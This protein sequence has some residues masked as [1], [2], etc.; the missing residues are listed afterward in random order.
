MSRADREAAEQ[1]RNLVGGRSLGR[2]RSG[3]SRETPRETRRD[4]EVA[5]ESRSNA[6]GENAPTPASPTATRRRGQE[7]GERTSLEDN[8]H[9]AGQQAPPETHGAWNW[10]GVD[11]ENIS[12]PAGSG[13]Q[14]G[15]GL[16]ERVQTAIANMTRGDRSVL[17]DE[18]ESGEIPII[19]DDSDVH[20]RSH[21]TTDIE[22]NAAD[23]RHAETSSFH[24]D[25]HDSPESSVGH[26]WDAG[27]DYV[28][29]IPNGP[30]RVQAPD[31]FAADDGPATRVSA[32]RVVYRNDR[33]YIPNFRCPQSGVQTTARIEG[34][35]SGRV[36]ISLT[37]FS[38]GLGRPAYTVKK[39]ELGIG[40]FDYPD[41]NMVEL[42]ALRTEYRTH[43]VPGILFVA[44][45]TILNPTED[46]L[47]STSNPQTWPITYLKLKF[48][49]NSTV[50][51]AR[52]VWISNVRP[53]S[54]A[55]DEHFARVR[56]DPPIIPHPPAERAR[57]Q[58][59]G[60][61][62]RASQSPAPQG[63]VA[64]G[65]RDR[66][67][68]Q[69]ASA[70]PPR[71]RNSR[72]AQNQTLPDQARRPSSSNATQNQREIPS[73]RGVSGQRNVPAQNESAQG[74]IASG[75]GVSGQ[76]DPPEH[77]LVK[78]N[79][80]TIRP[81]R[82]SCRKCI[83]RDPNATLRCGCRYHVRCLEF[84]S[85]R[86][87]RVAKCLVRGHTAECWPFFYF[88]YSDIYRFVMVDAAN[89][90]SNGLP[91]THGPWTDPFLAVPEDEDLSCSICAERSE[92]GNMN[93]RFV[94]T[95]CTHYFHASCLG[96]WFKHEDMYMDRLTTCPMCRQEVDKVW[97]E[98]RWWYKEEWLRP[99]NYLDQVTS[100][101]FV[102]PV[103]PE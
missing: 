84:G 73:G 7:V 74:A 8:D 37:P 14:R 65:Q 45:T 32:P 89:F 79:D 33:Y 43:G 50:W 66:S 27:D 61:R 90:L 10:T 72:R 103:M 40:R 62:W 28:T 18:Q 6:G 71:T 82:R 98:A 26:G 57:L 80:P 47:T 48:H 51:A 19:M 11:N 17:D 42:G 54:L 5:E 85:A 46:Q 88:S 99:T 60:D 30:G 3:L 95:P 101:R 38:I 24:G 78:Y 25:Y 36:I 55:I 12:A 92:I 21:T 29:R 9:S 76:Q 64:T 77:W 70:P 102:G 13:T 58:E 56:Q 1:A 81:L 63:P 23:D 86:R 96:E 20:M 35:R 22:G 41:I 53:G 16:L 75:S 100:V 97:T 93:T 15:D 87:M 49:D 59:D 69:E 4:Q 52:S 34:Q 2:T 83:G 68:R 39:S 44:P 67:R 94:A 31:D 91:W